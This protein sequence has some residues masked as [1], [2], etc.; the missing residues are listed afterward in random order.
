MNIEFIMETLG[1]AIMALFIPATAVSFYQFRLRRKIKEYNAIVKALSGAKTKAR[2]EPTYAPPVKNEYAKKDYV[3]PVAFATLICAL[4]SLTLIMGPRLLGET[5][6]NLLLMGP[7]IADGVTDPSLVMRLNGML[8]ISMA[9][10]GSYI[11]AIQNLVRRL[12][13]VDLPP[14]AYYAIAIRI[15]MAV[16]AALLVYYS[17]MP[18]VFSQHLDQADN[19][20]LETITI[21]AFF[22]GMFPQR[23]IR[24]LQER[25]RVPWRQT[26]RAAD[27]LPLSMIQGVQLY[28]RGRLAEVGIDNSQNL[29]EANLI[30]L[31]LRTP[32]NPRQLIDWIGQA[33]LYVQLKEDA[34]KLRSQS[35]RTVFDLKKLGRINGRIDEIAKESKV[36]RLELANAYDIIRTDRD[37]AGLER[38]EKLLTGF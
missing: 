23:A 8:I 22:A 13:T 12:V 21:F 34:I 24:W 37:I 5:G 38:A 29:A 30:E 16:F 17:F 19:V 36:S 2:G 27:P 6:R 32:F 1:V 7:M 28:Q 15:I 25:V 33:K 11:W 14:G 18:A 35:V 3:V 31:L 4:C 26:S 10:V 20:A 9:F